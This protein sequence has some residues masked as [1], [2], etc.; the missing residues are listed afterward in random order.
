MKR[1]NNVTL[2]LR[3]QSWM[4]QLGATMNEKLFQRRIK[5]DSQKLIAAPRT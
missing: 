5:K 3:K 4:R 2:R 1:L